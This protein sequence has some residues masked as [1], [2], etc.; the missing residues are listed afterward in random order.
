MIFAIIVSLLYYMVNIRDI[1][2]SDEGIIVASNSKSFERLKTQYK[3][4]SLNEDHEE[5]EGLQRKCD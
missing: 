5:E 2:E 3:Y 1:K 4:S